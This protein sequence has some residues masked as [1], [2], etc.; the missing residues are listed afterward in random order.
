MHPDHHNKLIGLSAGIIVAVVLVLGLAIVV[1]NRNQGV[2]V[3]PQVQKTEYELLVDSTT[4]TGGSSISDPAVKEMNQS[5]SAKRSGAESER[6]DF[7]E[8]TSRT[9]IN[10]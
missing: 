10:N 2:D 9:E 7:V 3:A 8:A 5:T 4:A 6:E 1:W